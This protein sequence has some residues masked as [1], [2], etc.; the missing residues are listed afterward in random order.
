MP[1]VFAMSDICVMKRSMAI[2][3]SL[4]AKCGSRKTERMTGKAKRLAAEISAFSA[5][6]RLTVASGQP[7]ARDVYCGRIAPIRL[8]RPLMR[9]SRMTVYMGFGEENRV[10]REV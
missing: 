8:A 9:R 4:S 2:E 6:K 5:I 3:P 10:R 1:I 7:R